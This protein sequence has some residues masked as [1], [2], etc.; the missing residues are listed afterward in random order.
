MSD[1][2][3]KPDKSELQQRLDRAASGDQRAWQE[4]VE[5]YGPRVFGLLRAQ[6]GDVDLAEEIAQSTFCTIAS[7][8][9]SYTELGKFEAWLFRIAMNRL[10]DEMR[11]R[12][13][14]ARPVEEQS[15]IGMAGAGP[16]ASEDERPDADQ[17][18]QLREGVARLSDAEQKVLHLRYHSELSFKQI[19]EVLE[20]PLGT[21]LA[22]QHR[23][24]KKLESFLGPQEQDSD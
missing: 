4:I 24:L 12:K 8:I 11:R 21:I 18:R 13:R 1:S 23:A 10:R 3:E 17:L 20:Q 6:C 7:K 2:P 5:E 14:Q 22:R 19:A 9:A 16:D 15:L